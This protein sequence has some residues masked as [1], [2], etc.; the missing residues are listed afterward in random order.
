MCHIP[1]QPQPAATGRTAGLFPRAKITSSPF[2]AALISFDDRDFAGC[3]FT[4]KV[5][6]HT[7]PLPLAPRPPIA[8]TRE[9]LR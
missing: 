2:S 7:R 4:C 6:M 9:V 1:G 3:T 5:N 8:I